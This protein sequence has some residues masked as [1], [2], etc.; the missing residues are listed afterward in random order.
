MSKR[1]KIKSVEP[2]NDE[3]GVQKTYTMH[4][5]TYYKFIVEMDNGDKGQADALRDSFRFK[6]GDDVF[7]EHVPDETHGDRLKAFTAVDQPPQQQT[8]AGHGTPQQG[9]ARPERYKE[10]PNKSR[11]IIAQSSLANAIDWT[12][13]QKEELRTTKVLLATAKVFEQWVY[14][15]IKRH[16]ESQ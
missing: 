4:Q 16:P 13:I 3:K 12:K 11:K 6:S 14:D 1:A 10:D 7:Y 15:S 8:S 2:C 9:T 5:K